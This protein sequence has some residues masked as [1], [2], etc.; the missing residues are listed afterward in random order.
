MDFNTLSR[1]QLQ[2][3]CKNNKIPANITNVAMANALNALEFVEGIEEFLNPSETK[4]PQSPMVHSTGGGTRTAKGVGVL[5]T[6]GAAP[7]TATRRRAAAASTSVRRKIEVSSNESL[8]ENKDVK[9]DVSVKTPSAAAPASRRRGVRETSTVKHVYNTRRSAR[10]AEKTGEQK[11]RSEAIKINSFTE[12]VDENVEVAMKECSVD[13]SEISDITVLDNLKECSEESEVKSNDESKEI[14]EGNSDITNGVVGAVASIEQRV[15]SDVKIT[16]DQVEDGPVDGLMKEGDVVE[17]NAEVDEERVGSEEIQENKGKTKDIKINSHKDEEVNASFEDTK[18]N[19]NVDADSKASI[20]NNVDEETEGLSEDTEMYPNVA[21]ETEAFIEKDTEKNS[22]EVEE[23]NAPFEGTKMDSNVDE[24]AKAS[25]DSNVDEETKA[26]IEATGIVGGETM[27]STEENDMNSNMYEE[28]K[29]PS[30]FTEKTEVFIE[31]GSEMNSN[32][33]E[34]VTASFEYNEMNLNVDEEAKASVDSNVDEDTKASTEDTGM[35][36][37]VGEE[38]EMN[39]NVDEEAK[40]SSEV[41]EMN[42]NVDDETKA[43]IAVTDMISEVDE[44]CKASIAEDTD[45]NS[46]EDEEID[47]AEYKVADS[48]H[49]EKERLFNHDDPVK[50]HEA[51]AKEIENHGDMVANVTVNIQGIDNEEFD[52]SDENE[53]SDDEESGMSDENEI[54]DDEESD[55]SD[56]SETS[57]DEESEMSNI[58]GDRVANVTLNMQETDSEE[59]NMSD[60]IETLDDEELLDMPNITHDMVSN[61]TVNT[62]ETDKEESYMSEEN[63]NSDHQEDMVVPEIKIQDGLGKDE[64]V[65]A[66]DNLESNF[67]DD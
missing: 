12:E 60:E 40:A 56:E 39:S 6:P 44:E 41:N 53:T 7:T 30:E 13:Q 42:S 47:V 31:K 57:E 59:S 48:C 17:T 66:K 50:E 37:K 25:I 9:R 52:M 16:S 1:R 20:D 14:S 15:A 23:V 26:P 63:V 35:N 43:P 22:S 11:E 2:F 46:N 32:E 58:S 65:D 55:M 24:E 8:D 10:L 62:Q 4:I 38:T 5:K 36:S 29:A 21:E 45:V 28:A 61:V 51:Y 3:L 19:S 54:S 18:T 34:E 64:L 27:A 67:A 49:V 33:D